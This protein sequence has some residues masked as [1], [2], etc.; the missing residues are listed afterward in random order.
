MDIMR[1]ITSLFRRRPAPHYGGW[2]DPVAIDPYAV[3]PDR[4]MALDLLPDIGGW[5]TL[6]VS[7]D[8][9][10]PHEYRRDGRK[11]EIRR[12]VD[13]PPVSW[14][15]L[16]RDIDGRSMHEQAQDALRAAVNDW[17]LQPWQEEV[18]MRVAPR[19]R[20]QILAAY[21]RPED[22]RISIGDDRLDGPDDRMTVFG[23]PVRLDPRVPRDEVWI[24]TP[25]ESRSVD[26][27]RQ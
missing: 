13:T 23:I 19:I 10:A 5:K 8:T 1:R 18:L 14:R 21:G 17:D 27:W 12:K 2:Q 15:D 24:E 16:L 9:V 26:L 4:V 20:E 25:Y 11:V 3:E 7:P 6:P 22:A